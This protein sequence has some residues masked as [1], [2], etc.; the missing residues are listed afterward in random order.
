MRYTRAQAHAT[1]RQVI[2]IR[3]SLV[4]HSIV[5]PHIQLCIETLRS[6]QL[7]LNSLLSLL[8]VGCSA[9]SPGRFF[10]ILL[11]YELLFTIDRAS[12]TSAEIQSQPN[13]DAS[14]FLLSPRFL[15]H[16]AYAIVS[17][18][19]FSLPP[20]RAHNPFHSTCCCSCIIETS[21]NNNNNNNKNP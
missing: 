21:Y 16:K 12:C 8:N 19:P 18:L 2:F 15:M 5:F 1:P 13:L 3:H 10:L 17:S 20:S 9:H 7:K 4:S 6:E 11:L 14:P